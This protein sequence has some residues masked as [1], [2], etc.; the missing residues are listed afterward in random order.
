MSVPPCLEIP[1]LDP[2][3]RADPDHHSLWQHWFQ[4]H[5]TGPC[6]SHSVSSAML[7]VGGEDSRGKRR[8]LRAPHLCIP[9]VILS[10]GG[11]MHLIGQTAG[12]RLA[13]ICRWMWPL[14]LEHGL[15]RGGDWPT[16]LLCPCSRSV[17]WPRLMPSPCPSMQLPRAQEEQRFGENKAP[18]LSPA[19]PS[20]LCEAWGPKPS[21]VQFDSSVFSALPLTVPL[22]LC[23]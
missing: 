5:P 19:D 8:H 10:Q 13:H 21:C 9:P 2:D 15:G 1:G 22:G 7:G 14:F 17:H 18:R 6:C 11:R 20:L 16:P 23:G 3:G 4:I 12:H